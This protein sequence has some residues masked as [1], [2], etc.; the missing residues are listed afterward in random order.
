[1]DA[2]TGWNLWT[3][4]FP[5]KFAP[6]EEVFKL[7]NPGDRIF[8]GTACARPQALAGSLL[9]YIKKHS[10][11][12]LD[13]ELVQ[14][15][16][17]GSISTGEP[18]YCAPASFSSLPDLIRRELLPIDMALIQTSPPDGEG[19]MSLGIGVDA[20]LAAARRSSLLLAQP[21]S[22]MPYVFGDGIINIQD[23][24]FIIPRDEPLLEWKSRMD[25]PHN[26]IERIGR[27]VARIVQDDATLQV[28][29]GPLVDALLAYLE[30]KR[31][32]GLHSEI[33]T[34]GAAR[35]MREGVIDN[36][37]KSIDPG[38]SV[39][40]LCLGGEETYSFLHK[41]PDVIFKGIDYTNNPA[42][43]SRQRNMT[44]INSALK[45]DLTGQASSGPMNNGP[46]SNGPVSN[47]TVSGGL[48]SGGVG[49]GQTDF[50]RSAPLAPGGESILALPSTSSDGISSCI[51]PRLEAGIC[52]TIDRGDVRYVAT[53][54]GI[55][56]LYGKSIQ[57]RAMDLIAI[58]HPRFR[59]WLME[60]ARRLFSFPPSRASTPA[61]YQE[62]LETWRRT[63]K[64]LLIFLRPV[65]MS[66][67]PLLQDFFSSLSDRSSYKRFASAK[68][69]MPRSRLWEFLPLDPSRGL[70]ILALLVQ[71][72]GE[73][74]IGL[75]QFCTNDS[76]LLAELALVV[77]D[78]FQGQGIGGILHRY[79]T[80]LGRRK[81]LKGFTA[82]VLEDNLPALGLITRMGF[83]VAGED[84]GTL[85]MRMLF[86][87]DALQQQDHS[88]PG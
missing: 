88:L 82:E 23:I 73:E 80:Y 3:E 40:S 55:A 64:G 76:D 70:V 59:P 26:I 47:G 56:Y 16:D 27:N 67:E 46:L 85:Q 24:D 68:R 33:F 86:D 44:A 78:D 21:N 77:H 41:N 52:G 39:A 8:I 53:E 71:E 14:H 20:T 79:M 29:C 66:D 11:E 74:I 54:Y 38:L 65:M 37:N 17:Q 9:D 51:L 2:G 63:K 50:M 35:L 28:G 36:S 5:E 60:E 31:H 30:D 42:I 57:E 84:G 62:N 6:P 12:L 22:H 69:H 43:I 83:R 15:C 87:E 10:Q 34:D 75:G 13:L 1:M 58:S 7:L 32:L 49:G 18:A 72:H 45:I 25:V 81:G 61:E 4:T 48:C 19:D